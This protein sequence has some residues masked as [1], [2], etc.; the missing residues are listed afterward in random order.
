MQPVQ[1]RLMEVARAIRYGSNARLIVLRATQEGM[2][3]LLKQVPRQPS[4]PAPKPT[5]LPARPAPPGMPEAALARQAERL[6]AGQTAALVTQAYVEA[7]ARPPAPAGETPR[8]GAALV[9]LPAMQGQDAGGTPVDPRAVPLPALVPSA[10]DEED[11]LHPSDRRRR[12]IALASSGKDEPDNALLVDRK[13][14]FIAIG[15]LVAALAVALVKA[16]L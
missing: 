2:A 16:L 9:P 5:V 8:D 10:L 15:G 1:A 4:A 3:N 11:D 13:V 6:L 7:G 12:A 14:V